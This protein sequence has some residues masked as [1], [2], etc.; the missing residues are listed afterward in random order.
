METEEEKIFG[1]GIKEPFASY[2]EF[3]YVEDVTDSIED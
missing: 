2:F 1:K 3:F